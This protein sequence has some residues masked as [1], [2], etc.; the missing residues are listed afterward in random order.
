MI[1]REYTTEDFEEVVDMYY[2]MCLEVYPHRKFKSKQYFYAN[3]INWINWKY[4]IMV[5]EKDGNITGF[6]MCYFDS[7][8]GIVEDYYQ[9]ECYY[10]KPEYRKTRALY[11]MYNTVTIYCDSMGVLLSGSASSFTESKKICLKYG[12][13]EVF[14]KIERLPKIKE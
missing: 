12:N 7:M 5:T 14:S 4:D 11:L 2:K 10:V 8:G 1:I 3:V 13:I 9:L 6:I